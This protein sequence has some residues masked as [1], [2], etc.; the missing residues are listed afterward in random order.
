VTTINATLPWTRRSRL[1]S[2]LAMLRRT[3]LVLVL[4]LSLALGCAEAP[5]P[6]AATPPSSTAPSTG[7]VSAAKDDSPA[8]SPP[9]PPPPPPPVLPAEKKEAGSSG[10]PGGIGRAV[11]T[12]APIVSGITQAEILALVNQNA[13]VFYRCQS[14]GAG[15]SK[16]WR[17]AV[18]I[19]AT[20]SPTGAVN[21][22]EVVD[23]TT[24]SARVDTCV[25]DG[26]KKLT[27]KRP[28]GSGATVFTF[29]MHFEPM[30]QVP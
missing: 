19:K 1:A 29:P 24:K 6:A 26:F 12:D 16:S 7:A 20:V 14:L 23:S 28:P 15:A 8:L 10:A 13:D 21:A 9:P 22:I 11:A 25:K 5:P 18:T 17:A 27:F 2:P 4:P 30:E 3:A